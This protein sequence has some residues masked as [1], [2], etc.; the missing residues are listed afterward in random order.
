MK[1]LLLSLAS[2]PLFAGFA[3][4]NADQ[5]TPLDEPITL[6]AATLDGVTAAGNGNKKDRCHC[7]GDR[8][9]VRQSQQGTLSV[10]ALNSNQIAVGAFQTQEQGDTINNSGNFNSGYF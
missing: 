7:K 9:Q 1:K 5:P 6:D 10:N 8:Q 4:A 3:V 2:V